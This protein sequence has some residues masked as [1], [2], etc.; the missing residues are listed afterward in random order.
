MGKVNQTG[1]HLANRSSSGKE[2]KTMATETSSIE[3]KCTCTFPHSHLMRLLPVKLF[4]ISESLMPKGKEAFFMIGIFVGLLISIVG[5]C[6]I[7]QIRSCLRR[8]RRRSHAQGAHIP[9]A[10]QITEE[11]SMQTARGDS[12][13]PPYTMLFHEV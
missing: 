8:L 13:P 10:P 2:K 7:C 1:F 5:L 12:P 3:G 6:M 9:S 11:F 4:P